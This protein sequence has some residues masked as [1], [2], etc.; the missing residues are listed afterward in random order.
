LG[1]VGVVNHDAVERQHAKD[2]SIGQTITPLVVI[3]IGSTRTLVLFGF[4]FRN[5]LIIIV[6]GRWEFK[7]DGVGT[8]DDR[9]LCMYVKA[10]QP[11]RTSLPLDT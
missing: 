3:A 4:I 7:E 11:L 6:L 5:V 8:N 9:R 10:I 2:G 1:V